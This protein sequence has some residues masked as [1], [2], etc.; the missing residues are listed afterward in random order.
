MSPVVIPVDP[1]QVC[2]DWCHAKLPAIA[3]G[4]SVGTVVEPTV[5]PVRAIRFRAIGGT[6]EHPVIDRPRID[7]RVWSD[8]TPRGQ[9]EAARI[10]RTVIAHARR[11]LGA[12]VFADPVILPDPADPT[13][14]LALGTI[15]LLTRGDQLP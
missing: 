9:G 11:D 3:P 1:E 8:G 7:V 15:Q 6:S 14:S 5:T 13:K 2:T 12:A 4:Y 10:C